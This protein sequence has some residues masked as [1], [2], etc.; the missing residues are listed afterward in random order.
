MPGRIPK[1]VVVGGAYVDMAIRCGQVPS[2]GQ[3]VSGSAV[4]YTATGP[5]PNQSAEAALCGCQ[6][7]LISKV[8][9]DP[10]AQM[11]KASLAEFDI[12]TD[13]VYAAEAKNTGVVVTLVNAE[14]EN[15]SLTYTGANTALGPQD[16]DAAETIIS[17][18]DICLIHG[19]LPERA[20]V[21]A[22]RCARLHG[23]K[24]ILNP[25]RPIERPG[26][27]NTALPI[28]YFSANILVPNLYEA[29]N[30]VEDAA[31]GTTRPDTAKLIGSDLVARGAD[32]AVI[33]MGK[34]GCL[35]VDR[36]GADHIPAFEVE[37]VDQTARGDAFAGA[38]AA[39]S[40]VDDNL[41]EAVKFASAAG[42]LA[43]TKFGALEALPA[44]AEI[45]ELLQKQET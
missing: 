6:V 34:R 15:T 27:E 38:L 41:R 4:F 37:L 32:A 7:H 20:V 33:T 17:D 45:I 40:A 43:C 36:S 39:F 12:N 16:I 30:I 13:F 3:S 25:A 42:A 2:P 29:A 23:T 1:V 19:Q 18:A 44:K 8:G 9:G 28:D 24:V 35:V 31:T 11:V 10:F 21:T 22:I 5:G 26:R 14:G